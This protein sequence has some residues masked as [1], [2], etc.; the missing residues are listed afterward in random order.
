MIQLDPEADRH[1]GRSCSPANDLDM[2]HDT[3]WV[4]TV[5][6]EMYVRDVNLDASNGEEGVSDS[7]NLCHKN[8]LNVYWT[9][10]KWGKF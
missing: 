8:M 7:G 6:G 4:Q 2:S 1:L 10:T 5:N 9:F 3:S